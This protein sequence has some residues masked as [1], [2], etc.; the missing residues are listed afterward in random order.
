MSRPGA[1]RRTFGSAEDEHRAWNLARDD[2]G[3]LAEGKS[4]YLDGSGG[5]HLTSGYFPG[6]TLTRYPSRDSFL[7]L[8]S[9]I[10]ILRTPVYFPLCSCASDSSPSLLFSCPS[11]QLT[12]NPVFQPIRPHYG[13]PNLYVS[14]PSHHRIII[15][16]WRSCGP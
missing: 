13:A 14:S 12:I 2:G 15:L 10:T 9:G 8:P 5:E 11:V 6:S 16:S 7:Q 3:E 4:T 1:W